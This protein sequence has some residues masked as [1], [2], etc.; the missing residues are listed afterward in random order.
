MGVPLSAVA[1]MMGA[2]APT[3]AP[4]LV[5]AVSNPRSSDPWPGYVLPPVGAKFIAWFAWSF[6]GGS[7][8]PRA[9]HPVH[10][11]DL[12]APRAVARWGITATR[13][14]MNL[15]L[16][17]IPPYSPPPGRGPQEGYFVYSNRG[18]VVCGAAAGG[19]CGPSVLIRQL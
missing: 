4:V 13:G 3:S 16:P 12:E 17:P 11:Y 9:P 8:E 5:F 2:A 6:R 14:R 7:G 1:G 10:Y 18:I 19:A 15:R